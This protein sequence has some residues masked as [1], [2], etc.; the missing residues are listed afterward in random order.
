MDAYLGLFY[1]MCEAGRGGNLIDLQINFLQVIVFR[2][3]IL[4][5]TCIWPKYILI[6]K[7]I[8]NPTINQERLFIIIIFF[9]S[10]VNCQNVS[11]I[12]WRIIEKLRWWCIPIM[13]S[14][15]LDWYDGYFYHILWE[16][17]QYLPRCPVGSR[18]KRSKWPPHL[19]YPGHFFLYRCIVHWTRLDIGL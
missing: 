3:S 9:F 1:L 12:I 5:F 6:F 10:Q 8:W 19:I 11:A 17:L 2:K 15:L 7:V 13:P 4:L 14:D 18:C 16:V